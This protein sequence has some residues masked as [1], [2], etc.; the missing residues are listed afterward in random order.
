MYMYIC[1][2]IYIY[3]YDR[4]PYPNLQYLTFISCVHLAGGCAFSLIGSWFIL[5]LQ[6]LF[7][8]NLLMSMF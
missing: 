7:V 3:A 4:T 6:E 5:Y 8:H 2:Y 1:I